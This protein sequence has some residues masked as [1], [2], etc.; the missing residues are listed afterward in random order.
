MALGAPEIPRGRSAAGSLLAAKRDPVLLVVHL[1]R[2]RHHLRQL[3]FFGVAVVVAHRA[4]DRGDAVAGRRRRRHHR[5]RGRLLLPD[6]PLAGGQRVTRNDQGRVF[7]YQ[8]L[9]IFV[10]LVGLL[11][12]H[13]QVEVCHSAELL[14]AYDRLLQVA[15]RD[16]EAVAWQRRELQVV[17]E[18]EAH[19]HGDA[20]DVKCDVFSWA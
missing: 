5:G 14:R 7:G 10:G 19:R 15:H 18:F 17:L 9:L 1:R 4:D 11:V 16:V 6:L 8:L 13:R 3:V 20:C 12:R 2:V